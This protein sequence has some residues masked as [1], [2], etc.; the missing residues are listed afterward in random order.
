ME[1]VEDV[2]PISEPEE[3]RT[4]SYREKALRDFF[5]NE[6]LVDYDAVGACVRVGYGKSYAKEFAARFMAEPYV[7]RT[8]QQKEGEIGAGS[9]DPEVAKKRIIAGLNR[10]ANYRGPGSS[11]SA[12][13]AALS[14]LANLYGMDP[15]N[16]PPEN[17][18]DIGEGVFVLPGIMTPE[19]WTAAAAD[20]QAKLVGESVVTPETPPPSIH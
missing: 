3:E 1:N 2:L 4:Y 16:K 18:P 17:Q 15:T 14:R 12:R 6:Y 8:I 11:Q 20:Q 7:L 9:D 19:Q 10:E 13:V 5:I